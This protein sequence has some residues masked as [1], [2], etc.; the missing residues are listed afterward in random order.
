MPVPPLSGDRHCTHW[1]RITNIV[2]YLLKRLS[3]VLAFLRIFHKSATVNDRFFLTGSLMS[4]ANV[5]FTS[6]TRL[7]N[8]SGSI[9]TIDGFKSIFMILWFNKLHNIFLSKNPGE[10]HQESF[11]DELNSIVRSKH[12]YMLRFE[13]QIYE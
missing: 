12:A 3:A 1:K 7:L 4:V 8:T 11:E 10:K 9:C 13:M 5:S 6:L 2:D